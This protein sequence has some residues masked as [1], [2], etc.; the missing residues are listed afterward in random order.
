MLGAGKA[1]PAQ[2]PAAGR[3]F[4]P[5]SRRGPEGPLG[6]TLVN[7]LKVENIDFNRPF[8]LVT[9]V[10]SLVTSF[11]IS[12]Q[13]SSRA[14]FAAPR[15]QP[16]PGAQPLAAFPPYGCGRTAL[17]SRLV[18]RPEG[19]ILHG[20]FPERR[21]SE[22][23]RDTELRVAEIA[24]QMGCEN[25]SKFAAVF[26]RQFGCPPLEYRRRARLDRAV[27]FSVRF[28]KG[29]APAPFSRHWA[30]SLWSSTMRR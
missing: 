1:A 10:I 22:L 16:R 3:G 26:A 27:P 25:Q 7:R 4:T 24:A 23:L 30:L 20:H 15:F 28:Q 13:S 6:G 21:A 29:S 17:G 9:S 2:F 11:F 12:L 8:Q 18:C 5:H 14:H 19:V